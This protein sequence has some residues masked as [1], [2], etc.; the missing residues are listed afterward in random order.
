MT[1]TRPKKDSMDQTM[2]K[3]KRPD[4]QLTN[5]QDN[6]RFF[7]NG[8][9]AGVDCLKEDY[10]CEATKGGNFQGDDQQKSAYRRIYGADDTQETLKLADNT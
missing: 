6:A 2:D 4:H 9:G 1:P 8:E 3:D 5:N 7:E 10:H